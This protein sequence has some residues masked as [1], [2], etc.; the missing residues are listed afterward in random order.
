MVAAAIAAAGPV[1]LPRDVQE[2]SQHQHHHHG[3]PTSHDQQD[4]NVQLLGEFHQEAM[5]AGKG[6]G[7]ITSTLLSDDSGNVAPGAAA[8]DI[9]PTVGSGAAVKKATEAARQAI[10][11]AAGAA[12]PAAVAGL[13]KGVTSTASPAIHHTSPPVTAQRSHS[14]HANP[15]AMASANAAAAH[16]QALMAARSANRPAGDALFSHVLMHGAA[17]L[18]QPGEQGGAA[19]Q[20]EARKAVR[21]GGW[22]QAHYHNLMS[23]LSRSNALKPGGDVGSEQAQAKGQ[24]PLH[25]STPLGVS[26][27]SPEGSG[28]RGAAL[29]AQGQPAL[30]AGQTAGQKAAK[31]VPERRKTAEL[32]GQLRAINAAT[33][34]SV[35]SLL[36]KQGVVK[37]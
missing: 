9:N 22:A 7:R 36:N 29:E 6:M 5:R 24:P 23:S 11:A 15:G 14:R 19:V 8:V 2:Y 31:M 37:A 10:L 3:A 34:V 28:I 17:G 21:A 12:S 33:R 4:Q 18:P 27:G 1:P 13:I 16:S 26:A 35:R 20:G 32:L 30:A 25:A